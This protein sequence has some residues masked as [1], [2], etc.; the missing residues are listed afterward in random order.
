MLPMSAACLN[1]ERAGPTERAAR[2]GQLLVRCAEMVAQRQFGWL[3]APTAR[4]ADNHGVLYRQARKGV[5]DF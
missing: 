2:V 5:A 1:V 4:K 3:G